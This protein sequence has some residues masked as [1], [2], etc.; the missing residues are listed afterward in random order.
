MYI[1]QNLLNVIRVGLVVTD[2]VNGNG[3]IIN[4]MITTME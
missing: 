1:K 3:M 4:T 2:G